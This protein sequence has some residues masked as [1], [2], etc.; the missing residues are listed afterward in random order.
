M[1]SYFLSAWRISFVVRYSKPY[2]SYPEKLWIFSNFS[3]NEKI[4]HV[5]DQYQHVDDIHEHRKK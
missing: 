4:E 3:I 2:Q 1:G 5:I